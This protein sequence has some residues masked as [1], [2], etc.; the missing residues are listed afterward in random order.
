MVHPVTLDY[1]AEVKLQAPSP[2]H[3]SRDFLASLVNLGLCDTGNVRLLPET[4][5]EIRQRLLLGR[6]ID[7]HIIEVN[8]HEPVK[9]DDGVGPPELQL[10]PWHRG[11]HAAMMPEG[12]PASRG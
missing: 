11:I 10:H 1:A 6:M 12:T 7:R 3:V 5:K 4:S 9:E 8:A 2:P